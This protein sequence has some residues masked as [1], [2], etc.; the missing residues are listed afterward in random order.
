MQIQWRTLLKVIA[1]P[2][3]LLAFYLSLW[4]V[5]TLFDL[6][7]D[8]EL[9]AV[10]NDYFAKHGLWV[11][12]LAALIEGSLILGQYFP[13]GFVIFIGVISAGDNIARIITVVALVCVAFFIAYIF[14]YAV[15]RFGWYRLF[16]KLGLKG[17]LE[18]A[19]IK[20]KR[21]YFWGIIASYWEP[22]LAS[23][24]AT[25]AGILQFSFKRFLLYSAIAVVAW[26]TIW[27]IFVHYVGQTIFEYFGVQYAFMVFGIWIL[28]L[29]GKYILYDR[30]REIPI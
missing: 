29:V 11:L 2:V 30:Q 6:P 14:N 18:N 15:G 26:N 17:A 19:Q 12:F 8:A 20:L 13:G 7:Q 28:I 27:G 3:I 1:G 5:W 25:A 4:G 10:I 22:N 16:L 24:T 9:I 23:I 21:Q